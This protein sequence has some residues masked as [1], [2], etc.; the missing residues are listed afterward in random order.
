[1]PDGL[2][3]TAH[4]STISRQ[5]ARRRRTV[6]GDRPQW[7]ADLPVPLGTE[8]TI[9]ADPPTGAAICLAVVNT[10]E[11][12]IGWARQI[13]RMTW[14]KWDDVPAQSGAVVAVASKA[15]TAGPDMRRLLLLLVVV[16]ASIA[17]PLLRTAARN[18]RRLFEAIV[19]IG[20]S[21]RFSCLI[22]R[23]RGASDDWSVPDPTVASLSVLRA[24][25]ADRAGRE[26][27]RVERRRCAQRNH[28]DSAA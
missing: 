15:R 2:R 6:S 24:C 12:G 23:Q 16:S 10:T 7:R 11:R 9:D 22:L 18:R 14:P 13:D 1:M 4:I 17:A 28:R 21:Q 25:R 19:P 27:D 20:T 3:R 26:R 8:F 5:A